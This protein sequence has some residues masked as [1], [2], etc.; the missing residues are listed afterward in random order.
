MT[1][2]TGKAPKTTFVSLGE[3]AQNQ[4]N[5]IRFFTFCP[6]YFSQQLDPLDLESVVI[7][8]KFLQN[9]HSWRI[10][11]VEDLDLSVVACKEYT[12]SLQIRPYLCITLK[13]ECG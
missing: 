4:I 1:L 10:L 3:R 6:S 12:I 5:K 13:W 9:Q 2:P 8:S 7:F 11:N